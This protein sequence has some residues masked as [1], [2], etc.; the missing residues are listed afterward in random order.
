MA[1]TI[2]QLTDATTVNAADEL[3]IQQGGITKRATGAE[4]A[5]GLNTINAAVNVKDL[6]AAGDGLAD[7][8][9]AIQAA[10]SQVLSSGG[11]TVDFPAGTYLVSAT[12]VVPQAVI[13]RGQGCQYRQLY[14][15]SAFSV[16]GSWLKLAAGSNVS[17]I[18]A[19][20]VGGTPA[21]PDA[22]RH[23]GGLESI[24]VWGNRSDNFSPLVRDSNTA[25]H[26]IHIRGVSGFRLNDVIVA[27]CAES[28][29]QMNSQD[30]G[31]GVISPNNMLWGNVKSLS[32]YGNGFT[33]SGGDSQFGQIVAGFNGGAGV[34]SSAGGSVLVGAMAWNNFVNGFVFTN[35]E[36][37]VVGCHSYDNQSNGFLVTATV[38]DSMKGFVLSGCRAARNGVDATLD[39]TQRNGFVV[40]V[41]AK[42][43]A[44]SGCVA[45]GAPQTVEQPQTQQRGFYILNTTNPI[46]LEGCLSFDHV[47]NDL[48]IDNYANLAL[49]TSPVQPSSNST[50][51]THSGF[52]AGSSINMNDNSV[53][54]VKWFAG[55]SGTAS[56]SSGILTVSASHNTFTPSS[57]LNVTDIAATGLGSVTLPTVFIRNA[58]AANTFTLVHNSTKIR[59]PA[60]TNKTVG[61]LEAVVVRAINNP[62]TIWQVL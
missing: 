8:T 62:P 48:V 22:V 25:G 21:S 50:Q 4:L 46:I 11:G 53:F 59:C 34:A 29:V 38:A 23:E 28:G 37:N 10:I 45:D 16:S 6:G 19:S 44:I 18:E 61:V 36:M 35:A 47:L 5:K 3:I 20:Y 39:D 43:V 1:K 49:H 55:P 60:A 33:L 9:A 57:S 32:N 17:V 42:N 41:L 15:S 58:S 54:G 31:A 26:G 24:G 13:L 27:R 14:S 40:G 51:S 30:Y 52:T 56:E 12:I 7:D 2:P